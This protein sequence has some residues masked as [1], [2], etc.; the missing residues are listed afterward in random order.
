MN[1]ILTSL[2]GFY[3]K[4]KEDKKIARNFGNTNGILDLMKKLTPKQ[5]TFVFV[6]SSESNYEATD[7]YAQLT[8]D[9]YRITY[10]FENYIILDGRTKDRTEEIIQNAD[11]IFLCG[12]HVPSQNHFSTI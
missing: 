4:D 1:L 7:T 2:L 8:F 5:S 10:P 3:Y 11:L 9:S 6:A 12:G